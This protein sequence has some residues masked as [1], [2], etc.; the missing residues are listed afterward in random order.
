MLID[1]CFFNSAAVRCRRYLVD[2]LICFS[3]LCQCAG[4]ALK[5]FMH[6]FQALTFCMH[7]PV[8]LEEIKKKSSEIIK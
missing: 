7:I 5:K 1:A 6:K 4:T 8:V 2:L 3:N